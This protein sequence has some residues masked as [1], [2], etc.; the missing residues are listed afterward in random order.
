M[1]RSGN[2]HAAIISSMQIQQEFF[3]RIDPNR[4]FTFRRQN[5]A[6]HQFRKHRTWFLR[7]TDSA[8]VF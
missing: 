8:T 6:A 1:K 5:F 4:T 7:H 2:Q 3:N